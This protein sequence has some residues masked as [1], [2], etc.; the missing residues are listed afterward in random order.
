MEY[1]YEIKEFDEKSLN[2]MPL[3]ITTKHYYRGVIYVEVEDK[4]LWFKRKKKVVIWEGSVVM[5]YEMA[6]MMVEAM[7]DVLTC[8]S[9]PS[10]NHIIMTQW[11]YKPHNSNCDYSDFYP[12]FFKEGFEPFYTKYYKKH[13]KKK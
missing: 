2:L 6:E 1:K 7:F 10:L 4:I 9:I 5:K 8:K 12:E 11:G 13:G 3:G